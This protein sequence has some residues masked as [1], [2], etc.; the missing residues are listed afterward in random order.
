MAI[1]IKSSNQN[2]ISD[3]SSVN[4]SE[5]E[6]DKRLALIDELLAV[7]SSPKAVELLRR[8]Q[9]KLEDRYQQLARVE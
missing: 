2:F 5:E 7:N 8:S 4:W 6:I 9:S 3:S 1:I